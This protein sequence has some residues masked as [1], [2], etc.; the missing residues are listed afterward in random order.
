MES[1]TLSAKC[2]KKRRAYFALPRS[3]V[4]QGFQHT[5]GRSDL[6]GVAPDSQWRDRTVI[7]TVSPSA[8]AFSLLISIDYACRKSNMFT[9]S[10]LSV[11]SILISSLRRHFVRFL[12]SSYLLRLRKTSS[13]GGYFTAIQ[14]ILPDYFSKKVQR[15]HPVEL[16]MFQFPRCIGVRR[17]GFS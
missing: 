11:D 9:P 15:F 5:H 10:V 3:I 13:P 8:H 12:L 1:P 2:G 16:N 6:S 4:N 7:T 14:L 17:H